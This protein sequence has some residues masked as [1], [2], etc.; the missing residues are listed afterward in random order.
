MLK[1]A[2]LRIFI[3]AALAIAA[4]YLAA[5]G[6]KDVIHH[7]WRGG[8]CLTLA[9]FAT[10]ASFDPINFFG[11]LYLGRVEPIDKFAARGSRISSILG[12]LAL[13]VLLCTLVGQHAFS[14][15]E[16]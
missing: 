3:S 5:I 13:V 11:Y 9:L 15:N 7:E 4:V 12:L 2:S 6:V 14:P 16:R 8:Y 1:N 10:A